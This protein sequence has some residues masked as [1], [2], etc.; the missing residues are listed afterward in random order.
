MNIGLYIDTLILFL[1]E[2][3]IDTCLTYITYK[4]SNNS[5]NHQRVDILRTST[6]EEKETKAVK[7]TRFTLK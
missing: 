3:Q 7:E 4:C 1:F 5:N 6:F 2:E